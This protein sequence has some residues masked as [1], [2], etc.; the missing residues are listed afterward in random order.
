MPG[1][2]APIGSHDKSN[3]KKYR[4]PKSWLCVFLALTSMDHWISRLLPALWKRIQTTFHGLC[5]TL[6]DFVTCMGRNKLRTWH[7][8][9]GNSLEDMRW[10]IEQELCRSYMKSGK[11]CMRAAIATNTTTL[12][13]CKKATWPTQ[14]L[15]NGAS[16]HDI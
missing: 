12:S 2:S 6:L 14:T 5:V 3:I 11:P 16:C 4:F 8:T 13:N 1:Q 9:R 15:A 10:T 7:E